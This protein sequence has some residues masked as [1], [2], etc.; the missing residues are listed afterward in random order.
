MQF[1]NNA[2]VRIRPS[3]V[4]RQNVPMTVQYPVTFMTNKTLSLRTVV[5][6][7]CCIYGFEAVLPWHPY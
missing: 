5:Y 4:G 6:Y 2:F 7:D 1:Y 3:L